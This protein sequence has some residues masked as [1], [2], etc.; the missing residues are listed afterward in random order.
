VQQDKHNNEQ[1]VECTLLSYFIFCGVKRSRDGDVPAQKQR[2]ANA[3]SV[4][5]QGRKRRK[6][7]GSSWCTL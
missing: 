3:G 2:D 4:Q 1:H 7:K 5:T 6:W